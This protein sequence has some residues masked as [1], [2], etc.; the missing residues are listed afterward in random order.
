[1]G[2]VEWGFEG[3]E[4]FEGG[5]E[6]ELRLL[7][8]V[9]KGVGINGGGWEMPCLLAQRDGSSKAARERYKGIIGNNPE[10]ISRYALL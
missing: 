3:I 5:E 1:M 10:F 6:G 2:E 7:F 4:G 9:A 8:E